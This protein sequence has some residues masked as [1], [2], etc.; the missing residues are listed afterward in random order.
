MSGAG[1]NLR[2]NEQRLWARHLELAKIGQVGETGNCRLALSDEDAEARALFASWCEAAGMSVSSDRAG[3]M[4]ALRP[5]R[6][7]ERKPV[8]AGSHLD[9]QPH[10]GRFDGVSGVLAALEVVETLNEA[11]VETDAPV[12]VI[13]WTNEEGVRFSPGLLGSSWFSGKI[14]D[15]ALDEIRDPSGARLVDE[16]KRIGWSGDVAPSEVQLDSFFELHI[17]QGPILDAAELEIGVVTSIQGLRWLDVNVTGFDAHAGTTPMNLRKDALLTAA[18]MLTGLSH[19]AQGFGPDAR[20][21]VGQ[22]R[23]ETDGPSTISGR[24]D[25]IVDVRHPDPAALDQLETLSREICEKAARD[26]GCDVR[27]RRRL[28][29]P[30]RA[31]DEGCVDCVEQA[32][33]SLNLSYR[34]MPSGAL[35][36]AS[37]IASLAPASMIFVPCRDG[38][39]HNITEYASPEA[40]AKGADVLLHAMLRRAMDPVAE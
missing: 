34:R 17:E 1:K 9:T 27:I 29:V 18:A 33:Q 26:Y 25:F 30:P 20:V 13:N 32:T 28:A 2:V 5:G 31:F 10:G 3:N 15:A 8:S 39:S 22:L 38:I 23:S 7:P 40:L 24:A 4:F 6:D 11:G 12:M 36:D 35:H 14:S 16:A 37:N 19:M 21:S